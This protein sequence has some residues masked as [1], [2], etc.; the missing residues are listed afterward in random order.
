MAITGGT[1][2]SAG[3]AVGSP[4]YQQR[5]QAAWMNNAE[6][7]YNEV[8]TT[9][10]HAVRAQFATKVLTGQVPV[11]NLLWAVAGQG[12]TPSSTDAQ[13]D[14]IIG[15]IWNALAGA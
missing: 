4:S 11:M 9:P 5:A 12:A 15:S 10:N 13:L 2:Q 6:S 8:G 3:D 14:T 7:V 1:Y